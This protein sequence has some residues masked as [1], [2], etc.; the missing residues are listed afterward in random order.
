MLKSPP[1]AHFPRG[2]F[3]AEVWDERGLL[4][5]AG[6]DVLSISRKADQRPELGTLNLT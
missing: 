1:Q 4:R 6:L 3:V 2:T 5:I